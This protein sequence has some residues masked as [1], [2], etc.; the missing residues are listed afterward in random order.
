MLEIICTLL[1]LYLIAIFVRVVL[2]WFP[3]NPHGGF[4]AIAGFFYTI[5]DVVLGP[6][7]RAVP[8]LRLGGMGLDLSPI[9]VIF[10]IIILQD[11]IGC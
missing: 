4:A 8:V 5:T 11:I 2:S 1:R 9:I 6:L 7:R 10:G 3:I